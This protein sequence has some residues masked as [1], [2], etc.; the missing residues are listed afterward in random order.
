M[1][2]A[3]PG[4]GRTPKLGN[5][6]HLTELRG[7]GARPRGEI[8]RKLEAGAVMVLV[9]A[10]KLAPRP[11]SLDA[12]HPGSAPDDALIAFAFRCSAMPSLRPAAGRL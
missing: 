3:S 12:L 6:P 11:V 8:P 1:V 5:E 9:A 2:A 4:T 10:E 7:G